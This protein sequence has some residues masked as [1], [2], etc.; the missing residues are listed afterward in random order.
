MSTPEDPTRISVLLLLLY[1]TEFTVSVFTFRFLS[2]YLWGRFKKGAVSIFM[3]SLLV[4]S[5]FYGIQSFASI[6][7][8][9]IELFP[10][11]LGGYDGVFLFFWTASHI[12]T[13]ISFWAMGILVVRKRFDLHLS[14]LEPRKKR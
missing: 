8:S 13:T 10:D 7:K 11:V 5:C 12:G 4:F 9:F 1:L 3:L 6:L 2:T 14:R